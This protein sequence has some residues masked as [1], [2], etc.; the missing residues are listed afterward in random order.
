MYSNLKLFDDWYQQHYKWLKQKVFIRS[1]RDEDSF[2]DAYLN[3]HRIVMFLEKEI[4][5][6]TPFF[7]IAYRSARKKAKFREGRYIHPEEYFFQTVFVEDDLQEELRLRAL[8]EKRY[9]RIVELIKKNNKED[10]RLFY[11]KMIEPCCSY[12][13]LQLYTG[14]SVSVLRRKITGII[15]FI[16]KEIKDETYDL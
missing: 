5:D 8:Q 16:K 15:D 4:P 12:R 2:H 6:Y 11:L 3:L 14:I 13:E 1:D 7:I 10:F 9:A